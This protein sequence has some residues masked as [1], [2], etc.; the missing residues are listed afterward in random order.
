MSNEQDWHTEVYKGFEVH[1]T[2]LTRADGRWDF[3]VRIA[4]PGEDAGSASELSA[5]AGDDADYPD[6]KAALEAGF[7]KGYAMVDT[8]LG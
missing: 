2:P 7:D 6:A 5:S 8:L 3:S 1:V 4:Q